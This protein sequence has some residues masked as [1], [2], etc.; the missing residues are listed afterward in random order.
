MAEDTPRGIVVLDVGATNTKALL[1]DHALNVL[2]EESVPSKKREGPPYLAVDPAPIL[3]LAEQVIPAFD[4]I[5]AVDAVVPCTHGSAA[6]LLG[7]NG[8]LVLP[9]M[10]YNAMPPDAVVEAYAAAAPDFGEVLAPINPGGLTLARQ[11]WWQA[12]KW[13]VAFAQTRH[14]VPFAQAIAHWLGGRA[15][16]EVT[17]WGA[18]THL[19]DM[20][21]GGPSSLARTQGWDRLMAK[22]VPAWAV[23]GQ[24]KP[25]FCGAGLRGRGH[26]RA[27]IHDSSANYLRYAGGAQRRFALLSTGTWIIGFDAGAD[28]SR[29]DPGRDTACGLTTMGRTVPICR[30]QGGEEY[31]LLAGSSPPPTPDDVASVVARGVMALPNFTA[32][33]GPLPGP[34]GKIT[35]AVAGGEASALAALYCAQMTV[36]ALEAM[37]GQV[38]E[39]V[40]VDGPF[41]QNT[42]YLSLLDALLPGSDVAASTL[43]E[44]TA[45]GA[46]LLGLAEPD[47]GRMPQFPISLAPAEPAHLPGL[48]AYQIGW[49]KAAQ[50]R[51]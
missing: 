9:I 38:P 27:G 12:A 11:L 47:T 42:A 41:G 6:A 23:I 13:P 50:A 22:T 32:S 48:A 30:F 34:A 25:R 40:I 37:S 49:R 7:E 36:L 31:A 39:R 19:W 43:R 5:L 35:G 16:S 46:A 17:S 45:T 3:A 26:I 8:D 24:L 2:A 29:L 21:S 33:G 10:E 1:F 44:G 4:A 28:P 14:I 15:V 20:R 51:V 18:Q